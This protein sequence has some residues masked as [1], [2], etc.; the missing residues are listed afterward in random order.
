MY[1]PAFARSRYLAPCGVPRQYLPPC[2]RALRVG[3][4]RGGGWYVDSD[5]D[6]IE[7]WET[8]MMD[9][10]IQYTALPAWQSS[11]GNVCSVLG[12]NG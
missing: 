3:M 11:A 7:N 2:C 12:G 5:G 1:V 8:E 10:R 6:M 4:R 9:A